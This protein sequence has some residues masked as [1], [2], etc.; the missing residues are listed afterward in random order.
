MKKAFALGIFALFLSFCAYS[1]V[2]PEYYGHYFYS[3]FGHDWKEF[4]HPAL[5]AVSRGQNP[6]EIDGFYNFP[7]V[8][9]LLLPF[10]YL[11]PH[12]SACIIFSVNIAFFVHVIYEMRTRFKFILLILMLV[13]L[14]N[15]NID[16]L[17][18][19]G[20]VLPAGEMLLLVLKPQLTIG[21][22]VYFF[23]EKLRTKEY[24]RLIFAFLLLGVAVFLS[25]VAYGTDI[26]SGSEA[27]SRYWNASMFPYG[28]PLGIL[29]LY[30]AL[31]YH[32]KSLAIA[33]SPFFSPYYMWGSEWIILFGLCSSQYL[34]NRLEKMKV[35]LVN[36]VKQ[37]QGRNK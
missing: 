7:W 6:Y 35:E 23:F 2:T 20:F 28:V 34:G 11:T 33:S 17:V 15:G 3:V 19:L 22:I 8:L 4:F 16:G 25:V 27:V 37:S 14:A 1:I 13:V 5:S 36:R 24:P 21:Y 26:F 9:A 29:L 18:A 10:A 30:A 32:D 31:K 12:M